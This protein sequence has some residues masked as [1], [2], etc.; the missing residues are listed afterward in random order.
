MAELADYGIQNEQSDIRAHVSVAN[1]KVYVFKTSAG[2]DAIKANGYPTRF[3]SQPGVDGITAE[4]WCVPWWHIPDIR[5]LSFNSWSSW[6]DFS[7]NL[8]TTRKGQLAVEC[9][10]KVMEMGRFPFWVQ[11][12]EVDDMR[13]QVQGVDLVVAYNQRIQVKCDWM[14]GEE[15]LGTGNLFLQKAERN[16]LKRV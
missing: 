3:A 8:S 4:G 13:L 10:R 9:V 1:Q 5:P 12:E 6:G 11:A 7:I 14:G 16:P 2:I 15:P